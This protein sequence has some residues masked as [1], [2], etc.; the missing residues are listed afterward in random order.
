LEINNIG[1]VINAQ[2][3]QQ[4]KNTAS[5]AEVACNF[6]AYMTDALDQVNQAQLVSE[7]MAIKYAAGEVTDVHQVMVAGQKASLMLQM[8]MQVRNKAIEAYQEIM[9]MQ[10]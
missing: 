3:L 10:V 7:E 9:R 2:P 4:V 1:S 5:P 8:T 6:S